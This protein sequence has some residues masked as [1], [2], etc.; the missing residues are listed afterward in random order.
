MDVLIIHFLSV[1]VR[2]HSY[3]IENRFDVSYFVYISINF[4]FSHWCVPAAKYYGT[5]WRESIGVARVLTVYSYWH[6]SCSSL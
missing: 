1:V 5:N 6:P 4:T 2:C 3:F